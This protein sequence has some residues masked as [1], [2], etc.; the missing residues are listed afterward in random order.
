MEEVNQNFQQFNFSTFDG[1]FLTTVVHTQSGQGAQADLY[2][3]SQCIEGDAV[4]FAHFCRYVL[5]I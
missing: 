1:K 4:G 3:N 5:L 2:R